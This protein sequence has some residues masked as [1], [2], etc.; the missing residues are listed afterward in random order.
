MNRRPLR[1]RLWLYA[2]FA[3]LAFIF[4]QSLLPPDMSGEESGRVAAL[5]GR[6]FGEDTAV[7]IFLITYVR[8]LAHFTEFAVLG[9]LVARARSLYYPSMQKRC[10]LA[11]APCGLAVGFLDETL[12]IFTGRGPM[13][14]DVWIDGAGFLLGYLVVT[15]LWLWYKSKRFAT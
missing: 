12:Q 1:H 15:L 3:M 14:A 8:K 6:I 4:V 13:I 9:I 7:G 10:A 2:C 11:L 5:L